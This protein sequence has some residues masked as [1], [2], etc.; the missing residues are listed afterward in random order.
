MPACLF[1]GLHEQ[2]CL[3]SVLD[4]TCHACRTKF[5]PRLPFGGYKGS[6]TGREFGKEMITHYTQVSSKA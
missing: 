5:D 2:L 4:L 3:S 1:I 6:G